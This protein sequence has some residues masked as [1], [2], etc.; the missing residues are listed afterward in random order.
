MPRQ[1]LIR[2][3]RT[4]DFPPYSTPHSPFILLSPLRRLVGSPDYAERSPL[5]LAMILA[6]AIPTFAAFSFSFWLGP[7]YRW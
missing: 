3:L 2:L 4:E 5:L 1:T 6:V 7:W